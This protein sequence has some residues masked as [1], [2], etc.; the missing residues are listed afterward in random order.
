MGKTNEPIFRSLTTCRYGRE[1]QKCKCGQRYVKTYRL[2]ITD[3]GQK[4]LV[5]SGEEDLQAKIKEHFEETKLYNILKK[6]YAGDLEA[7]NRHPGIYADITG[8]PNNLIDAQKKIMKT[9]ETFMQLPAELRDQ[10]EN[11]VNVFMAKMVSGEA[12]GT[13]NKYAESK[14]MAKPEIETKE[15]TE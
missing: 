7:L 13:I 10:F 5:E 6:Y 14:Q 3:E 1:N 4:T 9:Q 8:M 15:V 12:I 11:D 2:E